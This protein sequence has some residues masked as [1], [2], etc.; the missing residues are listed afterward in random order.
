MNNKKIIGIFISCAILVFIGGFTVYSVYFNNGTH[1]QSDFVRGEELNN[2]GKIKEDIKAKEAI[3]KQV[4]DDEENKLKIDSVN[5]DT[6]K[7]IMDIHKVLNDAVSGTNKPT[8]ATYKNAKGYGEQLKKAA[9]NET[10][11]Y[12]NFDLQRAALN[13][14]YASKS[15]DK[16]GLLIAHRILHDLD[17]HVFN[18][19]TENAKKEFFGVSQT[20]RLT[21]DVPSYVPNELPPPG[22]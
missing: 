3:E 4:K 14:E 5:A 7:V 8:A 20:Y 11:K 15:N 13:L 19:N 22:V 1:T 16:Q 10:W 9:N 12:I 18:K 2:E 17:V 21:H 6:I